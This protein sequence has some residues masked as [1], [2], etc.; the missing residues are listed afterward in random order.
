M[1]DIVDLNV[2]RGGIEQVEPAA[3]QHALPRPRRDGSTTGAAGA[4]S[5]SRRY[6]VP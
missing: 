3:G 1:G 6:H 2:E 4:C 5:A